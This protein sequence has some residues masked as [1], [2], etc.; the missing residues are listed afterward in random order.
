MG[1]AGW[2]PYN[3]LRLVHAAKQD[4]AST[5]LQEKEIFLLNRNMAKSTGRSPS[6]AVRNSREQKEQIKI[7]EYFANILDDEEAIR[8][9]AEQAKN[10]SAFIPRGS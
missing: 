2:N 5:M 10:P 3:T 1:N 4:I 7:A 6:K 8:L 9:E